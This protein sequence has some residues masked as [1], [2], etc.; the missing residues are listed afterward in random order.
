MRQALMTINR[1]CIH[2]SVK[3]KSETSDYKQVESLLF[4]P[5]NHVCTTVEVLS[6]SLSSSCIL[7]LFK[8]STKHQPDQITYDLPDVSIY[9]GS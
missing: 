2:I 8:L 1:N 9:N 5:H 3:E 4:K 7:D 6:C